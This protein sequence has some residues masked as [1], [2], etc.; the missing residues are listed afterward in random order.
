MYKAE[1]IFRSKANSTP[2]RAIWAAV[3]AALLLI[4]L[5]SVPTGPDSA[6]AT[7]RA[8]LTVPADPSLKGVECIKLCVSS[9]Q[10]TPGATIRFTG[11]HLDDVRKVVFPGK[12]EKQTARPIA[13]AAGAVRVEV[14]HG[15]DDG[16]PYAIDGSGTKSNRVPAELKILPASAIPEMVFPVDGPT[17]FGNSGARFGAARNGHTHQGQDIIAACGLP[18]LNVEKATVAYNQYDGAAGN[19]VVMKNKGNNTSFA[20]MH[21]VK[22]SKLKV[23]H[24]YDA[25]RKI[26][27]VGETGDAVGC[28]LHFEYW[29][30][31][32][33]T[34]GKPI[35][36]LHFLKSLK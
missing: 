29:I 20:Y 10:A 24:T 23:G 12:D 11:A 32:W 13:A 22:P 33:Q 31:P 9:H 7:D 6:S 1:M 36:P 26:G 14:P 19:Y 8:G 30:G 28:H 25:G 2:H 17:D 15:S 27:R 5:A 16:H 18:I 34:G 35:D 21:L 4:L 3:F